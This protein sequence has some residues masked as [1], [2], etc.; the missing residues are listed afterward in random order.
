[1]AAVALTA[2]LTIGPLP[3]FHTVTELEAWQQDWNARAMHSLDV[4]MMDERRDM[5][6]RHAWYFDPEPEP[7]HA[8][9]TTNSAPIRHELAGGVEQWRSLVAVYF[10]ADQVDRALR[11]MACESGGDPNAYNPSGASGL[12]QILAS[13]ADNFGLIPSELFDPA[14]NLQVAR[15]L[16]DDGERRVGNGW[17]HWVCKG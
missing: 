5:R 11:V 13:W 14:T 8:A 17:V 2:A 10:P 15:W 9:R 4:G 7:V 1:M 16:W 6:A 3:L 12:M